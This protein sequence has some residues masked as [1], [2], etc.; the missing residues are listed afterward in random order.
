MTME[1]DENLEG[2]LGRLRTQRR[3]RLVAAEEEQT[4]G[5]SD[6]WLVNTV[7]A[8]AAE[9]E[10]KTVTVKRPAA[11]HGRGHGEPGIAARRLPRTAAE[12]TR[13]HSRPI[14]TGRP[15]SVETEGRGSGVSSSGAISRSNGASQPERARVIG[16][17]AERAFRHSS[18]E[19]GGSRSVGLT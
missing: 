12:R 11:G 19:A 2:F 13:Q 4:D 6:A 8:S 7:E 15:P 9:P 16:A 18:R 3:V 10:M 1:A 17:G 14:A 5:D